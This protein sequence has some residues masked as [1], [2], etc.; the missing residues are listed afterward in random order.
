MLVVS[1][2]EFVGASLLAKRCIHVPSVHLYR[3]SVRRSGS[4]ASKALSYRKF[5]V[6]DLV[7]VGAGHARDWW[8]GSA[9]EG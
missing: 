4:I 1:H 7:T 3:F 5:N 9:V 2:G 6:T 8:R